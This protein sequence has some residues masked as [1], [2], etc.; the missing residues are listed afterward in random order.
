MAEP[1]AA[2]QPEPGVGPVAMALRWL[3]AAV[4]QRVPGIELRSEVFG[5]VSLRLAR[6]LQRG[7]RMRSPHAFLATALRQEVAKSKRDPGRRNRL[8]PRSGWDVGDVAVA[9]AGGTLSP[10]DF[11]PRF[12]ILR[13]PRTG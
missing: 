6:A 5:R 2:R 13:L 10:P 3:R 11:W 7:V 1:A 8:L 9:G 12:S 4:A